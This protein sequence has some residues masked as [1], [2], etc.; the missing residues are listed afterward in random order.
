MPSTYKNKGEEELR[1]HILLLLEPNFEGSATGETFNKSGKTDILLRYD[2]K[3]VFIGE[4]KF[5]KGVRLF[6][7][8]LTNYLAIYAGEIQNRQ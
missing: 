6:L 8:L 1:D 2:G 3:N 5:W 4:C 7:I